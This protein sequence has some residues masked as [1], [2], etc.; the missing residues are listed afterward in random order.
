MSGARISQA[1][2]EAG[3]WPAAGSVLFLRPDPG[4]DLA[5]IAKDRAL[6]VTGNRMAH[7]AFA[8]Q[9]YPV[10]AV[11]SGTFAAA[12]IHMPRARALAR[13]LVAEASAAVAPGGA[14]W[15][16]GQ[17]TDGIDTLFKDIRARAAIV[18]SLA[19]AHGRAFSFVAGADLSDWAAADLHPVP[20]FVTRP[21]VF[22]ADGVDPG[23]ALL[24]AQLPGDLKGKGADLGAGWGWLAARV[25]A[26]AGV[27]ELHLVEAEADALDCARRNIGDNIGAGRAVFHWA[28]VT[29]FHPGHALD[30]VVTNPPFHQGRAA[31][32]ALGAAFIRAAAAMLQPGG[33]LFL[34]ANRTLPYEEGLRAAFQ[35]VTP[36]A[37]TGGFKVLMAARPVRRR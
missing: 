22:S 10:A 36:L 5:G 30:F 11:A 18:Q 3:G 25:L 24:A 14:I 17:K 20:G 7:D 37:A 15:V 9:G 4:A 19:K 35:T 23:S 32:P 6:V 12:L 8:A 33:R 1:I 21:G 34:V 28:D 13:A 31:E 16:D 29:R 27:K 26:Q 2:A